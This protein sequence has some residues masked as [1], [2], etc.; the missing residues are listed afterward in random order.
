[1]P[2]HSDWLKDGTIIQLKTTRL[3]TFAGASGKK[4]LR[5]LGLLHVIRDRLPYTR[6]RTKT[7]SQEVLLG[8]ATPRGEHGAGGG[9]TAG[10]EANGADTAEDTAGTRYGS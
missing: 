7:E 3:E 2:G 6:A 10:R 9:S 1:M 4:K 8:F 5:S